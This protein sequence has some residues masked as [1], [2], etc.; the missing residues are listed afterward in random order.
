MNF[1][2]FYRKY[3]PQNFAEVLGQDHIV[4]TLQ[5]A[6]AQQRI[7]HAY[8]FSGPRGTG[9]TS[10]ARVL[11]K[12]LNCKSGPAKEPCGKC[13]ECQRIRDG[14]AIDVIEID[15]ASNRG[16]DEIRE[17]RERVKFAPVAARYKVYIIDEVHMLTPEAFNALLKT[18]EEPPPHAVFIMATTEAQKVPATILSRCQRLDFNRIPLAVML[19]QLERVAKDEKIE[20]AADAL[21]LIGRSAE[22][23]MRDALS[24]FDQL[25]AFSS[26]RITLSDVVAVLGTVEADYLFEIADTLAA[27]DTG[28]LL[29]LVEKAADQGRSI[30]QMARDLTLHFRNLLL[31]ALG[32]EELELPLDQIARL[33]TQVVQFPIAYL[34]DA[35]RVL[36]GAEVNMKWHPHARLLLEVAL[37]DLVGKIGTPVVPR[38][39]VGAPKPVE[40][41]APAPDPVEIAQ[42]Q[43]AGW[44]KV[45]AEMK[46]RSPEAY[47]ALIGAKVKVDSNKVNIYF[48]RGFSFYRLKLD[49]HWATFE[50]VLRDIM[51]PE[52]SVVCDSELD[53]SLASGEEK[54]SSEEIASLFG[55]KVA[56][57]QFLL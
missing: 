30:P 33:K 20:V 52:V 21:Q 4:Q 27:K 15:A 56:T 51:G 11:A 14:F 47:V 44:E 13:E 12:A 19:K 39:D 48:E 3:R 9:K 23:A 28:K 26:A 41:P 36:S 35:V 46:V 1:I 45:M 16:I 18:L 43:S 24:L 32:R 40:K 50:V 29:N 34:M 6:I 7:S 17:L 5:N 55:G 53:T 38:R 37:L 42:P 22:G 25:A 54:V 57:E 2:S 8:L 49:E 10:M 31:V